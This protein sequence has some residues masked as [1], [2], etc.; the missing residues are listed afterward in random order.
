[1]FQTGEIDEV[2]G[3]SNEFFV[4]MTDDEQALKAELRE[5]IMEIVSG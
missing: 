1:M 4:I 2:P 3:Q 5:K